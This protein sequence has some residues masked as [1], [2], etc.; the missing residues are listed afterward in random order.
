MACMAGHNRGVTRT[1]IIITLGSAV[2]HGTRSK[3]E[4]EAPRLSPSVHTLPPVSAIHP[5]IPLQSS[6]KIVIGVVHSTVCQRVSGEA[7]PRARSRADRQTGVAR[8]LLRKDEQR[9]TVAD[10]RRPTTTRREG[11][12]DGGR[13]VVGRAE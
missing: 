8:P 5:S 10:G 9:L 6:P 13:V 7:R 1:S 4:A 3:K 11:T 2:L 12:R